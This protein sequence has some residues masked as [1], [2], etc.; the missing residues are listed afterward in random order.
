ML[1]RFS[2]FSGFFIGLP[3]AIAVLSTSPT[4]AQGINVPDQAVINAQL[5]E[6]GSNV[7]GSVFAMQP[8]RNRQ[9]L[10]D[11]DGTTY[12][13]TSL[14]PHVN[15]WFVLET[16]PAG[17]R[18]RFVHFENGDPETWEI[19]LIDEDG[20]A[21]LI[22]GEGDSFA[23]AP[24][25]DGE[26]EEAQASSLPYAPVCDWSLFVRNPV[27][28]NRTTR[29]AVAE[30]L[31]ENVIFGE[32]I[33]NLIKGAFFEDAF[34]VSSEGEDE[35][36][37]IDGVEL[38]GTALLDNAPN[39]RP[40]MGFELAGTD[41]GAMTAGAWY[42]VEESPGIYASV[43]Q[44]GM[45]AREV[46]QSGGAN[47]LDSIERR[48]DVYL[49]AF[50][51]ARFDIGYE[52][53]TDHPGIEWSSRPQNRHGQGRGPDGFDT[54]A[55]LV[56]TGMLNPSFVDRVAATFTGGFKRDHGAWRF[57]DYA[58]FNY[59]HHYGF[60]QNGVLLSRLW[61]NLATMYLTQDGEVDMR[62]WT[63]EDTA[64]LPDL[65][66]ARQNGVAIVENGV[67]GSRV[68]SWGGGNWS[69]D[70]DATLRTLRGGACM[71]TVEGRQ[72]LIYAYFSTATPSAMART[73]QAY[74]CDY[75]ML[76]DMN[77]QEHTYMALYV[78]DEDGEGEID[79]QHLVSGMAEVDPDNGRVPRFISAPDNRDF[80]YL[81]R[82]Q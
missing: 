54:S 29:E 7:P 82:R 13:L 24:W 25:A 61:P 23:C 10:S 1:P 40:Y 33:V 27:T 72:F 38:L 53:G 42:E 41:A 20:P 79:V 51:M 22:E 45:I 60:M 48:A 31:R 36:E 63:E 49:V 55:P 4:M 68:T 70:A 34:M 43:M 37:E 59:G 76:L 67:P 3:A 78:H 56:R 75:A 77:S 44:P 19:S 17:G 80:F 52:L 26:L 15:S 81:L 73:F 65:V 28:G 47:G 30:F 66:F 16:T 6:L 9:T 35:V 14:N 8:F 12:T 71:R 11:A 5:A 18:S 50:D 74:Q 58:T 32:S 39:M 69:G 46:M 62:T 57:G 2:V 21:L 64:M